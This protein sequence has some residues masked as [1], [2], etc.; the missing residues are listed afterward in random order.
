MALNSTAKKVPKIFW[1]KF[2]IHLIVPLR[3][4]FIPDQLRTMCQSIAHHISCV[5]YTSVNINKM[6]CFFKVDPDEK[7]W[8]LWASSIRAEVER[9]I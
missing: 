6:V 9:L 4:K 7:V 1:L 8:F 5:S 3:G 2:L